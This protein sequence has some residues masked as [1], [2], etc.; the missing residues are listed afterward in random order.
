MLT[1]ST[2]ISI[3]SYLFDAF[4]PPATLSALTVAASLRLLVAAAIPLVILQDIT[5]LGGGWAYSIFGFIATAFIALP[6]IGYRW[7]SEA[8]AKSKYN[9]DQMMGMEV[10]MEERTDRDTGSGTQMMSTAD[11]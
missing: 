8:R 11:V 10:K 1:T 3:I 7:G 2:Q 5:A 9:K 4:P 6:F